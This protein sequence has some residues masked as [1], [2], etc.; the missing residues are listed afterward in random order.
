MGFF[1]NR[2]AFTGQLNG[3]WWC[4]ASSN[5]PKP[6]VK[7][8]EPSPMLRW[9]KLIARIT[10]IGATITGAVAALFSSSSVT[11]GIAL[12]AAGASTLA[13]TEKLPDHKGYIKTKHVPPRRTSTRQ[14]TVLA[15]DILPRPE[16]LTAAKKAPK[17]QRF[18]ARPTA[19]YERKV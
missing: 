11:S 19:S 2:I 1:Q 15:P 6:K 4:M 16:K 5:L 8:S 3:L 14:A 13:A 10:A 12:T 18:A 7:I 9:S 17:P